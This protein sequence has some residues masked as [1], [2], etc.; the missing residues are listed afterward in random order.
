MTAE[1]YRRLCK[2]HPMILLVN[3][4]V[5]YSLAG[6]LYY[7]ASCISV[8]S[9]VNKGRTCI[10]LAAS[11]GLGVLCD[12]LLIL[13]FKPL[14]PRLYIHH[15]SFSYLHTKSLVFRLIYFL[16]PDCVDIVLCDF[17]ASLIVSRYRAKLVSGINDYASSV[18]TVSNSAWVSH[19]MSSPFVLGEESSVHCHPSRVRL[20]FMSRPIREKG[21]LYAL[22]L[23]HKLLSTGYNSTLVL[24]GS[25]QSDYSGFLGACSNEIIASIDFLGLLSHSDVSKMYMNIDLLLLP[26]SYRNEVEPMVVLE[27]LSY[28]IPVLSVE[29]GCIKSLIPSSFPLVPSVDDFVDV[30]F[31]YIVDTFFGQYHTYLRDR[32]RAY[33]HYLSMCRKYVSLGDSL[34]ADI[35]T[36]AS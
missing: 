13:L 8:Y 35:A 22:D 25:N 17:M 36:S 15:H 34:I 5:R 27:S 32:Q 9:S 4:S 12:L 6:L 30:S 14:H 18:Y 29:R 1:V 21:F 10:Y 16:Y 24:A 7:L 11:G 2:L 31:D 26:T 28:A 19:N 33:D 20:G 3:R 23:H